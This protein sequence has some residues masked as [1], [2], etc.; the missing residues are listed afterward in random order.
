MNTS[1]VW[2]KVG[3]EGGVGEEDRWFHLDFLSDSS[4]SRVNKSAELSLIATWVVIVSVWL[5]L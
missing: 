3:L 5:W 1:Q 2:Y 4:P